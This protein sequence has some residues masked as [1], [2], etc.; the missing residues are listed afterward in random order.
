MLKL[1]SRQIIADLWL[2]GYTAEEMAR[3]FLEQ[4]L[5]TR[6]LEEAVQFHQS[7]TLQFQIEE[8]LRSARIPR[9]S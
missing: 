7:L 2:A 3:K 6:K 5:T 9:P 1:R 8:T 4:G